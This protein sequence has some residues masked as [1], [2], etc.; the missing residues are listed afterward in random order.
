MI[1]EGKSPH[2]QVS[3]LD[4]QVIL[5]HQRI[6]TEFLRRVAFELNPAMHDDVATQR[7]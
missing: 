4:A 1:Q 7:N 3:V 6:L 2:S 5:F